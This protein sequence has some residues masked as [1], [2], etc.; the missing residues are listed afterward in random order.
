MSRER[1]GVVWAGVG[2]IG[3]GIALLAAQLIGWDRLW[4]IFPILGGVAFFA[5]YISSGFKDAG[6]AFVGTAALLVGFF[7]FGFTF[8]FWEW[9]AMA[10][11]W[12]VFLLIGGIAFFVLFLAE[13]RARD[14][15]VL[16]VGCAAIIM[17][18]VGLAFTYGLV[19]GAILK[20]WP[21]LL[22]L[23]GLA[24]LAGA[25]VRGLRRDQS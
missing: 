2:L 11:L 8:G 19:G 17:G 14:V 18:I 20:Y 6:M 16:G 3:L 23:V 13:S 25:L 5:G 22:V 1:I 4:P 21:L 12:P 15:G 24:S 7:F 10:Q 9:E